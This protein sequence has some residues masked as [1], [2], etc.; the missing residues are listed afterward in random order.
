MVNS[1][2][3]LSLGSNL[4]DRLYNLQRAVKALAPLFIQFSYS[5]VL[6]TKAIVPSATNVPDEWHQPY[7]N[8]ILGGISFLGPEELLKQIKTIELRLGRLENYQRWAPRI[9]DI[10]I[11]LMGE[12]TI[13]TPQLTIPH[14][15]L[16]NRPFLI[17][18][19]ALTYPELKYQGKKITQLA[20]EMAAHHDFIDSFVIFPQFMGI[21]NITPDSFSDG[22]KFLSLDFAQRQLEKLLKDGASIIDIGAQSTRPGAMLATPAEELSRLV[23]ILEFAYTKASRLSIDSYTPEV[24]EYL[25]QRFDNLWIND[26]QGIE[27]INLLK[28]IAERGYKIITMHS[29]TL[30]PSAEYILG[31]DGISELMYWT[32][33]R[34]KFLISLGFSVDNIIIDPGIGFG[35]SAYQNLQIIRNLNK[36]KTLGC[37]ILLGH[38]RKLFISSFSNSKAADRDI[39]TISTAPIQGVEYLRVHDVKAHQRAF[40]AREMIS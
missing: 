3:Y 38:S 6:E 40:V 5:I 34:I 22:G 39:E 14:P 33:A 10:D 4:G 15:E 19:L 23:P 30:P 36:F 37:E 17:H 26:V 29:I 11:L 32:E 25:L 2:I 18:L 8:M 9:I 35:K 16:F 24:L 13:S 12:S 31:E 27:D 21:L 20:H 28:R 7:L 1:V